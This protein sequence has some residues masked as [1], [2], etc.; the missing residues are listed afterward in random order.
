M[1]RALGFLFPLAPADLAVLRR[2]DG[3]VPMEAVGN[4]GPDALPGPRRLEGG[5]EGAVGNAVL[6]L[7][8]APLTRLAERS[9]CCRCCIPL[10]LATDG[11]FSTGSVIEVAFLFDDGLVR[12]LGWFSGLLPSCS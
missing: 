10:E 9:I 7:S 6:F 11:A 3:G 12:V 1:G 5:P 4:A 2:L 8:L